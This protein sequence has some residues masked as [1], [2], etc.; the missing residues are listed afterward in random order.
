MP[1]ALF[2]FFSFLLLYVQFLLVNSVPTQL[3]LFKNILKCSNKNILHSKTWINLWITVDVLKYLPWIQYVT[4]W[5]TIKKVPHSICM[6]MHMMSKMQ[7]DTECNLKAQSSAEAF[8]VISL[9]IPNFQ[10]EWDCPCGL[11]SGQTSITMLLSL[12]YFSIINCDMIR[13]M[14]TISVYS[15][16]GH[17]SSMWKLPTK[18][19]WR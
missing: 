14:G 19:Y 10:N 4:R 15:G 9:V 7:P 6:Q 18:I 8:T 17:R 1:V 11:N 16:R 12:Q 13:P 5:I 2:L 3:L